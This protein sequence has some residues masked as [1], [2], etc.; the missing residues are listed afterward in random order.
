[1]VLLNAPDVLPI[2]NNRNTMVRLLFAQSIRRLLAG[3]IAV[4]PAPVAGYLV[5]RFPTR[6][7]FTPGFVG[8]VNHGS[9]LCLLPHH[10]QPTFIFSRMASLS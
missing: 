4:F 1:R 2:V 3:G 9:F 5:N 10:L 7:V 8:S 6:G